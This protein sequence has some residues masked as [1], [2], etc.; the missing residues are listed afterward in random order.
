MLTEF[1]SQ[2]RFVAKVCVWRIASYS[3]LSLLYAAKLFP[4]DFFLLSVSFSVSLIVDIDGKLWTATTIM[5]VYCFLL[6]LLFFS[7]VLLFI[8][9]ISC[10]KWTKFDLFWSVSV[11]SLSCANQWENG[12]I[13]DSCGTYIEFVGVTFSRVNLYCVSFWDIY[14]Y[15][16]RTVLNEISL[17]IGTIVTVCIK[18]QQDLYRLQ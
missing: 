12:N 6:Y 2:H 14:I 15:G 13:Q 11:M 7:L 17:F 5:S 18:A 4:C 1:Q 3:C 16:V 9:R 10:I 8:F